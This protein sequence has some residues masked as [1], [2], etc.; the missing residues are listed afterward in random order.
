M[1]ATFTVEEVMQAFADA[2]MSPRTM[3]DCL[4]EHNL[5]LILSAKQTASD[6][7]VPTPNT[8]SL[9]DNTL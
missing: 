9:A 2:L 6:A 4:I 7:A 8:K 5:R 3:R 1:E